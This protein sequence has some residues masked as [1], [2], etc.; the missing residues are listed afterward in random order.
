[1]TLRQTF[2]VELMI[3]NKKFIQKSW[4][5]DDFDVQI[6]QHPTE[7]KVWLGVNLR[8]GCYLYRSA[9]MAIEFWWR[10]LIAL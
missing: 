5:F 3:A 9:R 1:M 8:L 4:L 6:L 10:C 7:R 2:E